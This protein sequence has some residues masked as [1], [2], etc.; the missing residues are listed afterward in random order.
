MTIPL[1]RH[2]L[3]QVDHHHGFFVKTI[4]SRDNLTF[5]RLQRLATSS[6]ERRKSR[7]AL[8]D[9][10]H[11]IDAYCATYGAPEVLIVSA[12][13]LKH[14][15]IVALLAVRQDLRPVVLSATLFQDI[16]QVVHPLGIMAI[17]TVPVVSL[18]TTVPD[19][20]VLLEGVRDPG[21][22]GSIL[23]S[24]AAAGIQQV[25]LAGDCAFAWSPKTL[26][27]G[28][29]AHFGL[30]IHEHADL[31]MVARWFAGDLIATLP[32]AGPTL[33]ETDLSGRVAWLFGNEGE[34]LS[35]KSAAL[36]SR[37]VRIPMAGNSESLNVAA[38]AAV[39]F[40]ERVRQIRK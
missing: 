26:R 13:A 35:D 19:T 39:C 24:A 10:I 38:A 1:R 29:G 40:F 30:G 28:M 5:K 25:F 14:P 34:G 20:C 36:A 3:A 7:M 12:S 4:S 21:N 16:A 6:R 8:L 9:G 18:P 27:A 11:L 33:Y 31:G 2:R 15:E 23:R 32:G 17:C 22:L 37:S